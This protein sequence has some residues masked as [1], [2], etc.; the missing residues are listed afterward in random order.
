MV[1]ISIQAAHEQNN[2]SDL[3]DHVIRM[4][5]KGLERCWTSDHYMPWWHSG[6]SG[7]AAWPWIGAA[8]AKTRNISIG[9]GVTAPILRYHPAIVAQVFSTLSFMFPNRIFLGLGKGEAL[10]EIP[11]GNQW[12][13][14]QER[15]KRLKESIILIKKLWGEDWVTFNGEYYWVKDS[16]LYTKPKGHIPIYI[17]GN[18]PQSAK[19]AGEEGDGFITTIADPEI[20]KNRLFPAVKKGIQISYK[21]YDRFDRILFLITSYDEDKDKALESLRFWRGVMIKAFFEL[22][23]HDPRKIEENCKV[24]EDDSL[25]KN[26]FVISDPEE[27]IKKIKKYSDL[28][29]TEI[30]LTNASPSRHK[31]IDLI[32]EKINPSIREYNNSSR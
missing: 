30:V 10:N 24:I 13:S 28:G 3:L 27:G 2:P 4:D 29:F 12:P 21:D 17:A 25:E 11:S 19:L 8:L 6:A 26:F 16:N 15:F 18:G 23:I 7:G 9:T 31:L 5:N 1:K 14:N 20:L 32:G 22:D